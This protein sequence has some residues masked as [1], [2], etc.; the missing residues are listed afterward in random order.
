SHESWA[1]LSPNGNIT[2]RRERTF[3]M[4]SGPH[5]VTASSE[6]F[7]RRADGSLI[8][9][10][11][12][13]DRFHK[14][15]QLTITVHADGSIESTLNDVE[16]LKTL[17]DIRPS[18]SIPGGADA[19]RDLSNYVSTDASGS[20][21]LAVGLHDSRQTQAVKSAYNALLNALKKMPIGTS[22]GKALAGHQ[23]NETIQYIVSKDGLG[24][25][26]IQTVENDGHFKSTTTQVVSASGN[27][28]IHFE[29]NSPIGN[30][31]E[32]YERLPGGNLQYTIALHADDPGKMVVTTMPDGSCHTTAHAYVPM[33]RSLN[34]PGQLEADIHWHSF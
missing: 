26:T 28:D 11:S 27:V 24:K 23:R 30:Q 2:C 17:T 21:A 31:I 19:A 15:A 16:T 7:A 9:H 12:G 32:R 18:I 20:L 5:E 14:P 22:Q 10:V 1:M 8:Y 13:R 4:M 33:V 3:E 6:S 34:A 25:K 29:T